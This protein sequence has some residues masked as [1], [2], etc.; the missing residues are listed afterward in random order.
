MMRVGA[1]AG[2]VD[3]YSGATTVR[4]LRV[5]GVSVLKIGMEG[6]FGQRF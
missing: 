2:S 4:V 1:C 3:V 6:V 5:A